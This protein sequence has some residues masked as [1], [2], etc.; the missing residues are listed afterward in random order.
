MSEHGNNNGA[1]FRETLCGFDHQGVNTVSKRHGESRSIKSDDLFDLLSKP[2]TEKAP[3]CTC[4]M[5][6]DP[7]LPRAQRRPIPLPAN[8]C[9][10][11]EGKAPEAAPAFYCSDYEARVRCFCT[12]QCNGCARREAEQKWKAPEADWPTRCA[13][14]NL[15]I[16]PRC[17]QC[18]AAN[19][20]H[21]GFPL[22][23]WNSDGVWVVDAGEAKKIRTR[24]LAEM[25]AHLRTQ[26]VLRILQ[27]EFEKLRRE[28]G[29]G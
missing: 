15:I 11:H 20:G 5:T 17:P 3:L 23:E 9:P 24:L 12:I 16:G 29:N 10:I 22:A 27:A 26:E 19:M 6:F 28:R 13:H 25:T 2:E 21:G 8:D 18:E 7:S 1:D 4:K 14:G